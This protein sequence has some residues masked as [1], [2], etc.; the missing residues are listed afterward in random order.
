MLKKT[1]IT[2]TDFCPNNSQRQGLGC[3]CCSL[4]R[5]C[6]TGFFSFLWYW[7]LNSGPTPWAT[8]PALFCEGFFKTGS[9]KLFAW[10]GFEPRSFSLSASCWVA[11][12]TGVSHGCLALAGVW[13]W[14]VPTKTHVGWFFPPFVVLPMEAW[15]HQA[16]LT[17]LHPVLIL[18]W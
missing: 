3:R 4:Y 9:H 15:T 18:R 10:A 6:W 13:T 8:P 7:G 5:E 12:I 14:C 16:S 11:R 2:R 17:E 1:L